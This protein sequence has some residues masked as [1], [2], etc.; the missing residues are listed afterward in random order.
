REHF[1]LPEHTAPEITEA[2]LASLALELAVW[3]VRTPS[4]LRWLDPPPEASYEQARNLLW[5]LGAV[6]PDGLVTPEGRRMAELGVHPRMARMLFASVPL[7][8]QR[9]ASEVAVLL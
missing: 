2:D 6:G 3:G 1:H 4:D 8:L 7:G 9:L 5:Q